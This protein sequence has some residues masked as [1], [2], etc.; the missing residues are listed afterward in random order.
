MDTPERILPSDANQA[1]ILLADDEPVMLDVLRTILERQG[2]F[3]LA[4]ADGE[5]ALHLSRSFPGT[6]HL[7]LTD[8]RMPRMNGFQLREKVLEERP[9]TKVLLMS[10]YIERPQRLAF[11]RKP[12]TPAVLRERVRQALTPLAHA[13]LR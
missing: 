7:L 10:A 2:Y 9:D 12:F 4:A 8:I 3:I 1:V 6:I 11:L 13:V 5:A